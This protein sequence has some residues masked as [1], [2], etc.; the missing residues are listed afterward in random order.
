[1]HVQD[2]VVIATGASSGIGLATAK[3]LAQ[4]GANV[5][6]VARSKD[7]LAGG[8]ARI[9]A[10]IDHK[11]IKPLHK[12]IGAMIAEARSGWRNA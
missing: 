6:L 7:K 5:A 2:K 1:M 3:L 10:K 9:R 12:S 11:P 8:R 4:H